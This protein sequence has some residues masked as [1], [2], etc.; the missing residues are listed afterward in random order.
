MTTPVMTV[1]PDEE[2]GTA[3]GLMVKHDI[4]RLPV[5]EDDCI[6]GIIDRHDILKLLA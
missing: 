1:T 4:S 5:I 2:A 3:A 6:V